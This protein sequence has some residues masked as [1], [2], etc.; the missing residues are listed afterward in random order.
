MKLVS[1]LIYII[2]ITYDVHIELL[3]QFKFR[4]FSVVL[5]FC[6]LLFQPHD[7]KSE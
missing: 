3:Y 5:F 6:H 1:N 7:Y 4:L 2:E